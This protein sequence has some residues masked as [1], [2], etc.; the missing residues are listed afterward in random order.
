MFEFLS[1]AAAGLVFRVLTLNKIINLSGHV[2][3]IICGVVTLTWN[4]LL[5]IMV[6][7]GPKINP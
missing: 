1:K 4:F 5:I 3:E 6:A 2:S 7:P